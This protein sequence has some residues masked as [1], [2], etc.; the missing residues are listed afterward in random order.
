MYT[1]TV[2][3]TSDDLTPG[4]LRWAVK[5]LHAYTG[6]DEVEIVFDESLAGQ[7]LALSSGVSLAKPVRIINCSSPVIITGYGFTTSSN[8]MMENMVLPNLTVSRAIM[9]RGSGNVFTGAGEVIRLNDASVTMENF[10]ATAE[11]EG[12]YIGISGGNVQG[13]VHYTRLGDGLGVYRLNRTV[14]VDAEAVL[15]LDKGT[16]LE[17][18][19]HNNDL[20]VHGKLSAN[21]SAIHL[22]GHA[23]DDGG[24]LSGLVVYEGGIAELRHTAIQT[25][26]ATSNF[27]G[28]TGRSDYNICVYSGGSLLMENCTLTDVNYFS[29]RTGSTVT[30]KETTLQNLDVGGA[31]QMNGST[32]EKTLSLY[33]GATL[34]GSGNVFTGT[35][36]VV[37][38]DDA[39]V[40]FSD[41]KADAQ[42]LLGCYIVVKGNQIG[43]NAVYCALGDGLFT[44]VLNSDMT[45]AHG[46]MLTVDGAATLDTDKQFFVYGALHLDESAYISLS[47]TLYLYGG[48]DFSAEGV[49]FLGNKIIC[50]RDWQGDFGSSIKGCS[51]QEGAT[52]SIEGIVGNSSFQHI[53]QALTYAMNGMTVEKGMQLSF[54]EETTL[55]STGLVLKGSL[56]V[57]GSGVFSRFTL[58]DDAVLSGDDISLEYSLDICSE[59]TAINTDEI[60]ARIPDAQF[61]ISSI[62]IKITEYDVILG[63]MPSGVTHYNVWQHTSGWWFD[64]PKSSIGVNAHVTLKDG[65]VLK[66]NDYDGAYTYLYG[67]LSCEAGTE[68][69]IGNSSGG[70]FA[71]GGSKL[72]MENAKLT[73]SIHV[74]AGAE[75]V[76]SGCTFTER[77]ILKLESWEGDTSLLRKAFNEAK[78]SADHPIVRL[79]DMAGDTT[80]SALDNVAVAYAVGSPYNS[81][82]FTTGEHLLTLG[83]GAVFDGKM[84]VFIGNMKCLADSVLGGGVIMGTDS[85]LILEDAI[86]KSVVELRQGSQSQWN[87]VEFSDCHVNV[88][89]GA[90]AELR[91]CHGSGVLALDLGAS[92]VARNNDFSQIS[93]S[94]SGTATDDRVIDLSGN[95]WGTTDME[96]IL[97]RISGDKSRVVI[98]DI[99]L[100]DPMTNFI[101]LGNTLRNNMIARGVSSFDIQLTH[102]IDAST[103]SREN[104][105]LVDE[106]GNCLALTEL[107]VEGKN[108]HVEFAPLTEEASY[109]LVLGGDIKD[110]TGAVL[111][112]ATEAPYA[113]EI[114]SDLTPPRVSHL[115]PQGDF[116]GTLEELTIY[117]TDAVDASTLRQGVSVQ[118]PF[119]NRLEITGVRDLGGNAYKLLFAPQTAYGQ[120]TVNISTEVM[121]RAGNR[122]NQNGNEVA[123]EADDAFVGCFSLAEVDLT[124][125]EVQVAP[126]LTPGERT[127]ITWSG[128]NASGYELIGSWTDGV[129]LSKDARWDIGDV[130]LGSYSHTGGLA[131]G[132]SYNG[133]LELS[134]PGILPGEYYLLVRSD[135][136]GQEKTDKEVAEWVQ[137]L[138][139]VPVTVG[140][141]TLAV[142]DLWMGSMTPEDSF[143]Y[144]VIHQEAG[145]SL[146]LTLDCPDSTAKMEVF[147]GYGRVPS[148]ESYD[149]AIQ[150]GSAS[151]SL[152]IPSRPAGGDIYVLVNNKTSNV[153]L[154]Y[155]LDAEVI[156]MTVTSVTPTTQG[157]QSSSTFDIYGVNFT[158][159]TKVVLVGSDGTEYVPDSLTVISSE[160]IRIKYDA[161][162]LPAEK[163]DVVVS[164]ETETVT[165]E[166][167]IT[168]SSAS[169]AHLKIA[170]VVPKLLGYHIQ[171]TL[172][173]VYENTGTDPM[174]AP[175]LSLTGKQNGKTGAIL[176]LDQSL[177]NN[178]FWTSAMPEGFSN[179]VSFLAYSPGTPGWIMPSGKDDMFVAYLGSASSGPYRPGVVRDYLN[180]E[181]SAR[182]V[183]TGEGYKVSVLNDPKALSLDKYG[184]FSYLTMGR[185]AARSGGVY[186][187][188][189]YGLSNT[190]NVYYCGWQQPW[191]FSYPPFRFEVGY[192]GTDNTTPL[193]WYDSFSYTDMASELKSALATSIS[194][195]AGDTWGDY[196]LMLNKN[197]IYLDELGCVSAAG[198]STCDTDRLVAFEMAKANGAYTPM[199]VLA[200]S[201]D[202]A[203]ESTGLGLV[204]SRAYRSDIT[205]RFQEGAF[206]YGWSFNWDVSLSFRD[207][208]TV[209]LKAPGLQRVFQPDYR[210][211]Y[212]NADQQDKAKFEKAGDGSYTLTEQSGL[213]WRFSA[214][215]KL[216]SQTDT[217]G[218]SVS[219]TYDEEGKLVRL[220]HSNGEFIALEWDSAGHIS[221]LTDTN[222]DSVTYDYA[223]GHLVK[224]T[225]YLGDSVTY[226]YS[227]DF[228]HALVA[229]TGTDGL[230][231]EFSYNERGLLKETS[232]ASADRGITG[233]G[234]VTLTYGDNGE[235]TVT[236][237]YGASSTYYYDDKGH[238][239]RAVDVNGNTLRYGYD[240][241]GNM[242]WFTDQSG[243]TSAW[244]YDA[245][246]QVTSATNALGHTTTYTYTS[247]GQLDVLTDALGRATDYDY[248]ARGNMTRITYAD[249]SSESWTYDALGNADSWTNRRGRTIRSEYDTRGLL[250]ARFY[251]DGSQDSFTYDERGK[252]LVSTDSTGSTFYTYDERE[253]VTRIELS[254]GH[255]LSY[256]YDAADRRT[257]MTD[258]RGHVTRYTWN[259]MGSLA[260]VSDG[261]GNL[262]AEYDYDQGGRLVVERRGNGTTTEYS[263]T[264]AGQVAEMLMRDASGTVTSFCRYTYDKVGLRV[265][266]E[267]QDGT[268]SYGYDKIGQLTSA[269]FAPAEGSRLEAQDLRYEYDAAGNRTRSV[270]NGV[271][272]LYS[273]NRMNQ[274]EAAGDVL[275]EYDAD[276]NMTKK[277]DA[278]GVTLYTWDDDNQLIRVET[279]TGDVYAYTYNANGDRV[280]VTANGR[281]T[282]YVYDPSG[283]SN[284]VAEY[285]AASG[286]Q[287]RT[288]THGNGLIGFNDAMSGA[289]WYQGDALG[290]VTGITDSSGNLVATYSYDPFG[291]LLSP[292]ESTSIANPFQWVGQWGLTA[293]A[294]G[295]THMR[296]RYYD[297][298][299]G[300]FISADPIGI[301]GGLNLYAYC[302]NNGI[303]FVD[304]AG[305]AVIESYSLGWKLK[306]IGIGETRKLKHAYIRYGNGSTIG[307]GPNRDYFTRMGLA[308]SPLGILYEGLFEKSGQIIENDPLADRFGKP[309]KNYPLIYDDHY[310]DLAYKNIAKN[311]NWRWYRLLSNNCQDFVKAIES[312][313]WRLI[314]EKL[315]E[316]MPSET[317]DSGDSDNANSHDPNDLVGMPGF[318]ERNY[319]SPGQEMPFMIRFENDAEATAPTRWM[320]IFSTFDEAYD[321]DSFT[322]Q[323]FY[324]GGNLVEMTEGQDSFNRMMTLNFNGQ[325]VLVDVKINLDREERRLTGEFMAIDPETGNMIQDLDVGMLYPN[326]ESG[327]GDGYIAYTI[328]TKDE[329]TSGTTVNNAA[330][331]YF[332]F[333]E[334]IPTPE[335]N[336]TIDAAGPS[337]RLISAEDLGVGG[338]IQLTWEGADDADGS[339][340]SS[341]FIFVSRDGGDFELWESFAGETTTA[342]FAGVMGSE[343][344]FYV[345]AMDNVGNVETDKTEAELVVRPSSSDT[346]APDAV[347]HLRA[348]AQGGVAVFSWQAVQD[349]SGV[350]YVLEYADNP[351]WQN[352]KTLQV[353][354]PY[355]TVEN[356]TTGTWYWRV[357]AVDGV[358]NESTWAQ[359]NPLKVDATAPDMPA[360]GLTV[361]AHGTAAQ[362][363]WEAARDA[364][365]IASYLVE[366]AT[367]EDF[368][369]EV[370]RMRVS[371]PGAAFY[372][373][374]ENT[375]YY[376]RV[377]AVDGAGNIGEWV[378]GD[379]FRTGVANVAD[380]A[381]DAAQRI[382]LSDPA[383]GESHNI[384]LVRD[385]VGFDD[386]RDFY[387]FTAKGTGSYVIG[388]TGDT[389]LGTPVYLR[390]GMLDESG[391]FRSEYSLAV[392]PG[393][394]TTALA[395]IRLKEGQD[396]YI[397][398]S[399]YDNGLGRYNGEYSLSIKADVP[400]AGTQVTDDN[401]IQTATRLTA[402]DQPLTG[403]VGAGDA[404]DYYRLELAE[405]G[406][407][408]LNLSGLETAAKIKVYAETAEGETRQICS[409]SV[410]AATGL[411]DHTLSLTSGTYYVA[412]ASYDN[413]AGRYNTGYALELEHEGKERS[414]THYALAS[415]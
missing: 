277:T 83:E 239:R 301:D 314:N 162:S 175:L 5:Q 154:N 237:I 310:M 132:V 262:L 40:D 312:E 406:S 13:E 58:V 241:A 264:A 261:E 223:N 408:T 368:S 125:T 409:R 202:M 343:Y 32:V 265:A 146:R 255:S 29:A 156:P 219:C 398:V 200:S 131:A 346:E 177:M 298:T 139:A 351:G 201:V 391:A 140:I 273:V 148:R 19:D 341:F 60:F 18:L 266:M 198:N 243:N 278:S 168:I 370:Q 295:L 230:T 384:T 231:T 103:V 36:E 207:D 210:G 227:S 271:E 392:A 267:T 134:L 49:N 225:N 238:V 385:W 240:A 204:I 161:L 14:N 99:L 171:N 402:G 270:A 253:R 109:R 100:V 104:V 335:L 126:R 158:A 320:R 397:R 224:G 357:K 84:R 302:G 360:E 164:S 102:E 307:Y 86:C 289:Y 87:G 163:L 95:Y 371:S 108:I 144:L 69:I 129:Y 133:S 355:A 167:R 247:A 10:Q 142:N 56:D 400:E 363:S 244:S 183:L 383:G 155:T 377:A 182:T 33:S 35:G 375:T 339:G 37:R 101:Y 195:S 61:N 127:A 317:I 330:D 54:A 282:D 414:K 96:E 94:I 6:S 290:S 68:L 76:T 288:Y 147:I 344:G 176:T 121:D 232:S 51:F 250:I 401:S 412:I 23:R 120:Y 21:E 332:D 70:L 275:Y 16:V 194:A 393:S 382:I 324:L 22:M 118:A 311:G 189:D 98:N 27:D 173:V 113:A 26:N 157:Q 306:N 116:A 128:E 67:S 405:S 269:V 211:G 80:L 159:G 179:S 97:S 294:S 345:L 297:E 395:G 117:F 308:S 260:R 328:K 404:V 11:Q 304:P 106:S 203:V 166:D 184:S 180:Y 2:T 340:V 206:G 30:L 48:A 20:G 252:L 349:P 283:Y 191:D 78:F 192:L 85:S 221:R 214:D 336:Y 218:N 309:D 315:K 105:R 151:G 46:G 280:A 367:S 170:K 287:N 254:S 152:V 284:L 1:L 90:S 386:A 145:Q 362:L 143:D 196:V 358:G 342:T 75:I 331:I 88:K 71:I 7:T 279:S 160:R 286:E 181:N 119:G 399:A 57:G 285:D 376:W 114:R 380:D 91:A 17:S 263:Y 352:L 334:V 316:M 321:I 319:I 59:T 413:G 174:H 53:H 44:Y 337:S 396:C 296:A 42:D 66:V 217:N 236:D 347:S 226:A 326:D 333:N 318:G 62:T 268:W 64:T 228:A 325:D 8:L 303:S 323:S 373:L 281:T 246:G 45:I 93:I 186:I 193:N 165:L 353:D 256:T 55:T 257:S 366:Y 407:L 25:Y 15:N 329:L 403:W 229:V 150:K 208:G 338:K 248:D 374:A 365:G 378:E 327:R 137:N 74:K 110:I 169:G 141:P 245:A 234:K 235:V 63:A 272:T 276:G 199:Q 122:L 89:S 52:V 361:V 242:T 394:A 39:C 205:S 73:G 9:L 187:P 12:A 188:E 410:K 348:V 149:A 356:L 185:A 24:Y 197:L 31:M 379:S 124:V 299:T 172:Q 72:T 47:N 258:E 178:G 381:P 43:G 274:T 81:S 322:L 209:T 130:L 135:V 387:A 292:E 291:K 212:L 259:A 4:S 50:L 34:S 123:G 107:R 215:G 359:E 372:T 153:S 190:V 293:D 369:G 138:K 251:E 313:Y 388:L 249:G 213:V 3:N 354:T 220:T 77:E 38:L 233:Y 65:A 350:S 389:P 305:K 390:V 222:G 411:V 92:T 216:L 28:S 300:K 111:L 115:E 41:F 136:Y 79:V 364:S 415:R 112:P 82:E